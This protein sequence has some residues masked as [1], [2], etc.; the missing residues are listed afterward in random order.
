MFLHRG[1][2]KI[3]T[4]YSCYLIIFLTT[5][6]QVMKK[7]FFAALLLVSVASYAV[8]F[9]PTHMTYK[10]SGDGKHIPVSQV[11]AAV[12]ESF[13]ARYPNATNVQWERER[14]DNGVQ[15]KA[16]FMIGNKRIEARFEKD[17][18]FL[19]QRRK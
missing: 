4:G 19:G 17:G 3:I 5:K 1:V 14:E 6:K 15:Y 18:T 8:P 12:L 9:A 7:V 11:P 16:D 13:N 2:T 10:S